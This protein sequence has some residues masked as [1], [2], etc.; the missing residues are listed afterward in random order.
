[1]TESHIQSLE[2]R[3]NKIIAGTRSGDIY[4]LSL[5]AASEIKSSATDSKNLIQMV[6]CCNDNRAPKEIDFD[7][8]NQRIIYLSENG[9]FSI[10]NFEDLRL[11]VSQS[12]GEQTTGMIVFKSVLYVAICFEKSIKVLDIHEDASV[13][14]IESFALE[15]NLAT[16]DIRVNVDE[17][18]IA[19]AMAPN[20]E[21]CAEIK[22]Y[23]TDFEQ[24]KFEFYHSITNISSSI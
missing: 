7:A 22:I 11:R 3:F 2:F 12:F 1:M 19:V 24:K 14:S 8:N 20:Y 15:F 4:F 21:V 5:P 18:M 16:S 13:S 23:K 9:V 10:Y 17:S 6:Y